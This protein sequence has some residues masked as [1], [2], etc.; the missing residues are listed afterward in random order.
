M[1]SDPIRRNTIVCI[2]ISFWILSFWCNTNYAD[3]SDAEVKT[4]AENL[5][6][7]FSNV[8]LREFGDVHFVFKTVAMG[9]D[10]YAFE[11]RVSFWAKD[12]EFFRI[13]EEIL[14]ATGVGTK[15]RF[16]VRPSGYVRL[17]GTDNG[18]AMT[19]FGT[20]KEGMDRLEID[21]FFCS[22]TRCYKFIDGEAPFGL[23]NQMEFTNPVSQK[24]AAACTPLELSNDGKILTLKTRFENSMDGHLTKAVYEVKYD[25]QEGVLLSYEH[26]VNETGSVYDA[27]RVTKSYEFD[28]LRHIPATM[29]S[30]DKHSGKWLTTEWIVEDIDWSPVPEEVFLVESEGTPNSHVWIPRLLFLGIGVALLGIFIANRRRKSRA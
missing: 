7:K 11:K 17:A 16:I 28:R 20:N 30:E 5:H 18:F 2:A 26:T 9:S 15:T 14:G 6:E 4:A 27:C 12:G 23:V 8:R 22:S 19:S 25:L 1:G 29:K 21:E 3:V 13:D 10:D 24:F